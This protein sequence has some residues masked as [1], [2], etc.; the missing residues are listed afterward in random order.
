[1]N[2]LKRAYTSFATYVYDIPPRLL[3]FFVLI[4]FVLLPMM[5]LD[6]YTIY[7]LT[8][9]SLMAIFAASWDLLVGRTGQMSLGHALFYGIGGYSTALLFQRFG[10][11]FWITIPLSM[12]IGFAV[13]LLIG[14]PC[15]RLKGPYL[16]LVTMAFPLVLTSGVYYFRDVT[17]GEYGIHGL[18]SFFPGLPPVQ[19]LLAQ[20]YLALSL[21]AVSAI[22]LYKI[23]NSKTGMVFVS[24]LDDELSSKASGI[25]V[26]KYKLIAFG[27]S[28]L[29][30]SLAGCIQAHILRVANPPMFS[31]TISIVPLIVTILGGIG[32]I[33]GPLVGTYI[34]FLL[35]RYVF[36]VVIPIDKWEFF[37]IEWIHVKFLI[38][39]LIVVVFVLKWPR[40]IARTVV[41]KLEDLQEARPVKVVYEE[42]EKRNKKKKF[43]G[44]NV[45]ASS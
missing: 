36:T 26:T 32:T 38:F 34:Y 13:A 40:G 17:G 25:D 30:A 6:I 45:Y 4:L 1:M 39:V 19:R 20:Y 23:A 22:I 24:I 9:A 5:Q 16:A 12:L 28:G 7:T 15:L 41:D 35:D 21:L 33:Y 10:W 43:S 11:P 44:E 3:A 27:I 18:P 14:I 29:F 8:S 42:K 2:Y 31:L 37:G